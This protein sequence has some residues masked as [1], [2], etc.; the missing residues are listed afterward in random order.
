MALIRSA[1]NDHLRCKNRIRQAVSVLW[2]ELK[3]DGINS[4]HIGAAA[5][6]NGQGQPKLKR[7]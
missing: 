6:V 4:C 2:R 7:A 1:V 3:T 5:E